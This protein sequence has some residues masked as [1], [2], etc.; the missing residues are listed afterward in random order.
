METSINYLGDFGGIWITASGGACTVA[1]AVATAISSSVS[2]LGL[3]IILRCEYL[4]LKP[5]SYKYLG[6]ASKN[7]VE[8]SPEMLVCT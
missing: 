8:W 7:A 3:A 6:L 1:V 2:A 5:H 4:G